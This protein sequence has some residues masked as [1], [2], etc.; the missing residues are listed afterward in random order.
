MARLYPNIPDWANTP[1]FGAS[2][3]IELYTGDW[4]TESVIQCMILI[5]GDHVDHRVQMCWNQYLLEADES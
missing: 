4:Q 3:S 1:Y 2:A 5:V